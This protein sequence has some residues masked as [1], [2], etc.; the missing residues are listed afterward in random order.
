MC[1]R[2]RRI[3]LTLAP[4]NHPEGTDDS[5]ASDE[6]SDRRDRPGDGGRE[7]GI[8]NLNASEVKHGDDQ[9]AATDAGS[10]ADYCIWIIRW[11]FIHGVLLI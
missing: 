5:I 2:E 8:R 3:G 9:S 11:S 1:L 7:V 10:T 4:P 6:E